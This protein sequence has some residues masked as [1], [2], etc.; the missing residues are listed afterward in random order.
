VPRIK[1][2]VLKPDTINAIILK[3]D[4]LFGVYLMRDTTKLFHDNK[5][6][7]FRDFFK[8][9]FM[10]IES[11]LPL[12]PVLVSFSAANSS[13]Y[14]SYSNLFLVYFHDKDD[15]E[16]VYQ[17][18]FIIDAVSRNA[19]FIKYTHE[20]DKATAVEKVTNFNNS[21]RD[22][23]VYLQVMNGLYTRITIPGLEA[24]KNDP[25]MNNIAVNKARLTLPIMYGNNYY[26][27]KT[28]PGQL[29]VRYKNKNGEKFYVPD[30]SNGTDYFNGTPDSL[31]HVYSVNLATFVQSYLRD[32][33]GNYKPELEL[34]LQPS[35]LSNLILRANGNNKHIRFDFTYTKF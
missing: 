31:K 13:Y 14:G 15:N 10:Q 35:T 2:P 33:E 34:F 9:I 3:V 18:P 20:F 27:P 19:S 32:T 11:E 6:A 16:K 23:L 5:T 17:Y 25:G 24:I 21:V 1:L 29:Y 22:S 26:K 12:E 28:I 8:G 4:S 30:L 7:D